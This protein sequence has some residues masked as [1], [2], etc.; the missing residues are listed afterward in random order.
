MSKILY[1]AIPEILAN[2]LE[3]KSDI[4]YFSVLNRIHVATIWNSDPNYSLQKMFQI[5]VAAWLQF[6][7]EEYS[8]VGNFVVLF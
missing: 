6:S 2:Q 5:I 7:T 3:S 8:F 1:T 4:W